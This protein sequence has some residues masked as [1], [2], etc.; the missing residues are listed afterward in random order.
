MLLDVGLAACY[1]KARTVEL[2]VGGKEI[3]FIEG[4]AASKT[5]KIFMLLPLTSNLLHSSKKLL[6]IRCKKGL[7]V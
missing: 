4:L 5:G 6:G 7:L 3:R 1:L 2:R